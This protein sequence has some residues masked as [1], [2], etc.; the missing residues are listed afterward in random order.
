ML[1]SPAM[2]RRVVEE[3][4]EL[5]AWMRNVHTLKI[6]DSSAITPSDLDISVKGKFDLSKTEIMYLLSLASPTL[7]TL[8]FN[9]SSS[10]F[11]S[12]SLVAQIF[13]M[14]FANL[15]DLTV[16]GFY[17]YPHPARSAT[18]QG[19][20]LV[21]ALKITRSTLPKLQRL[22]LS[23]NRNPVGLLQA[24]NL[25]EACPSLRELKISGLAQAVSFAL[26]VDA[27]ASCRALARAR[28]AGAGQDSS[29]D[30]Q[31]NWE[32]PWPSRL[33]YELERLELH[34]AHLPESHLRGTAGLKNAEM[35]RVMRGIEKKC[36]ED[37]IFGLRV[38]VFQETGEVI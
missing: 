20:D 29:V 34:C 1:D 3:M 26:E 13:T 14:P 12:T 35:V 25:D 21:P 5:P 27:A 19:D 32:C 6:S 15:V 9:A 2:I 24:G 31:Q 22:H 28:A 33:P 36:G 37:E 16:V 8:I 38:Q 23:G 30:D 10:P 17:P 18:K 11:S 7:E 4:D